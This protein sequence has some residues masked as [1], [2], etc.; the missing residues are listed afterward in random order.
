MQGVVIFV[1]AQFLIKQFMGG[2]QPAS[3]SSVS[4]FDAS[5]PSA[6]SPDGSFSAIPQSVVPM[7]APDTPLDISIYLSPSVASPTLASAIPE[8]L[9]VDEKS[10]TIND[11]KDRR[12]IDTSFAVPAEVQKNGTLWAHFFV[13]ISG[14]ALDPSDDAYD[15]SKAYYFARPL[16]QYRP[17]KKVAKTKKLLGSSTNETA[18]AE[19]AL[20]PRGTVVASYYHPNVSVSIIP[21]SGTLNFPQM[22]PVMRQY[23]RLESSR[24]RDES[25]QNGW[26]YPILFINTFWQLR[27]HM[28]ELNETVKRLPLHIDL[29]HLSNWKFSIYSSIDESMKQNQRQIASGGPM[30]AGGDG[31]EL[32]EFKRILVDTN[33]YLLATTGIVSVL[34][35]VFEMLAFKSDIVSCGLA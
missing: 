5:R 33:I 23:V 6:D 20:Q 17:K 22:H 3:N 28:T 26:Y 12:H 18:G 2:N 35:M 7:W 10:I 9:V 29:D 13:A 34:H 15:P 31:S 1:A 27:D 24:A 19:E 4:T 8:Y 11:W 16:T 21:D 14:H 30:P 32:E 25:G